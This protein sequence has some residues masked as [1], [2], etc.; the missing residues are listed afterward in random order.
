MLP[1]RN[2]LALAKSV[3]TLD[4]LSGGR[5]ILAV[6]AGW[7]REE[8][9]ALGTPFATRVA[10]LQEMVTALR[11]LWRDGAGSF[12]GEHIHFTRVVCE[13]RP[14]QP[15]GPPIWIGGS[16]DAA[17]RRAAAYGDGWHALGSNIEKLSRG[18]ASFIG[19]AQTGSRRS[20][21]LSF[22]TSAG[23]PPEP[24]RAIQRLLALQAIGIDHVV[25]NLQAE[26]P[27]EVQIQLDWLATRV[28]PELRSAEAALD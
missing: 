24:E 7:L 3:S 12:D 19:Y 11:L 21:D 28:L 8:I 16:S 18:K 10:R 15:G 2:V 14:I 27:R 25:L 26:T 13:P 23:L 9:E 4:V 5:V 1:I 22:S 20:E 17:I 6:G